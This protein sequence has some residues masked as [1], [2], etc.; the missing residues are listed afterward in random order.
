MRVP[1]QRYSEIAAGFAAAIPGGCEV[2]VPE[3]EVRPAFRDAAVRR[4]ARL[5]A[6]PGP[7]SGD[8]S[9]TIPFREFE[10]NI[11]LA[12]AVARHL[13]AGERAIST[14]ITEA[15]PDVGSLAAWGFRASD[16]DEE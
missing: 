2:F 13:A 4:G 15:T 10:P 5:I 3:E 6:V 14:G 7:V 11:R 12:D 8:M 16:S 9:A 1:R